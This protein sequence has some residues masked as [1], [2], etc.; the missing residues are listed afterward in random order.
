MRYDNIYNSKRT[1]T[2]FGAG[3]NLYKNTEPSQIHC[4]DQKCY[5]KFLRMH[6]KSI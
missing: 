5:G 6:R 4:G 3:H 1:E 2:P